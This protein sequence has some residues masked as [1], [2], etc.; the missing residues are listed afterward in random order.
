M[1]VRYCRSPHQ[2]EWLTQSYPDRWLLHMRYIRIYPFHNA[3]GEFSGT[4]FNETTPSEMRRSL[5]DE[6]LHDYFWPCGYLCPVYGHLLQVGLQISFVIKPRDVA[7]LI[8][9]RSTVPLN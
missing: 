3:A 7:G 5:Y 4:L 8:L 6:H 1:P 2:L 9:P